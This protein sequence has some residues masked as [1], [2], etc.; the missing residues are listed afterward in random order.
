MHNLFSIKKFK[1][2]YNYIFL[3]CPFHGT[4]GIL[5]VLTFLGLQS[6][7]SVCF[8]LCPSSAILLSF[9]LMSIISSKG[10]SSCYIQTY[11]DQCKT[12]T[13]CGINTET[14]YQPYLSNSIT[15]FDKHTRLVQLIQSTD[16]SN[17]KNHITIMLKEKQYY[18]DVECAG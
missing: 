12:I 4:F 13:T 18:K 16:M 5:Q 7:A 8:A 15:L 3:N 6:K 14:I 11:T 1:S 2:I 9:E 10:C 17:N